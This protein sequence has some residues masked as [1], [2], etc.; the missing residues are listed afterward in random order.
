MKVQSPNPPEKIH[1]EPS[2]GQPQERATSSIP[3]PSRSLAMDE[4]RDMFPSP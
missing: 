1:T 4:R 3:S 2:V